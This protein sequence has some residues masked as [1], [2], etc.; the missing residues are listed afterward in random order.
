[1]KLIKLLASFLWVFLS[2][3]QSVFDFPLNP[4]AVTNPALFSNNIFS[5]VKVDDSP[6]FLYKGWMKFYYYVP[7]KFPTFKHQF[8]LN[9]KFDTQ[10]IEQ[11]SIHQ[12]DQYGSLDIPTSQSFFFIL[13]S[14][15]L[16]AL[17]S[18]MV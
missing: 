9:P 5:P 1:M 17:D 2:N 16:Y 10:F 8:E 18:R 14:K 15:A 12:N 4:N 11:T 13:T 7:E 6:K 3:C